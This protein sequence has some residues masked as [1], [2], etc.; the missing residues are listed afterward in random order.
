MDPRI[1]VIMPGMDGEREA[2]QLSERAISKHRRSPA[3]RTSLSLLVPR[4]P[5]C[6]TQC[7]VPVLGK[8]GAGSGEGMLREARSQPQAPSALS[9]ET[10]FHLELAKSARL[11]VQ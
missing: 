1:P 4:L 3:R 7:V 11:A 5:V 10:G 2:E 6:C 9:L 8:G